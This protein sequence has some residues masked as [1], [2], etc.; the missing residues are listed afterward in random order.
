MV[1]KVLELSSIKLILG[2]SG[3]S[4]SKAWAA[5]PEV[6]RRQ[7]PGTRAQAG[8]SSDSAANECDTSIYW[9]RINYLFNEMGV[10]NFGGTLTNPMV[11]PSSSTKA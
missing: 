11:T 3:L 9:Y 4:D 6:S 8:V 1:V 2:R 7:P 5:T 10:A